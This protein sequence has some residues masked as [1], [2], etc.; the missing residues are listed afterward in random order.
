MKRERERE[1]ERDTH[2]MFVDPTRMRES[3]VKTIKPFFGFFFSLCNYVEK[4]HKLRKRI[5]D[6]GSKKVVATYLFQNE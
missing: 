2:S 1:R 6:V 4:Q 5:V 3:S